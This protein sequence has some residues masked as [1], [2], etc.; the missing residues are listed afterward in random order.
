MAL[1]LTA[2]TISGDHYPESRL[3]CEDTAF[4]T[5]LEQQQTS[6]RY[7]ERFQGLIVEVRIFSYRSQQRTDRPRMTL[8]IRFDPD[9]AQ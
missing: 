9:E 7:E 3:D 4:T 8:K 2:M 6:V 5:R 1:Q